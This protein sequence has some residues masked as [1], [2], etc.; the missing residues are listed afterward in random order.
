[1]LLLLSYCYIA[2]AVVL[3]LYCCFSD[4]AVMLLLKLC[5]R[6][7]L[8]WSRDNSCSIKCSQLYATY[9]GETELFPKNKKKL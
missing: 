3:L 7:T 2:G 9:W 5:T 1:M 4:A 6:G 8:G